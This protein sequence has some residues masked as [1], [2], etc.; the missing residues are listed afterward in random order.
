MCC[1]M[2]FSVLLFF[3][4]SPCLSP[5]VPSCCTE[6]K[7]QSPYRGLPDSIGPAFDT[8]SGHSSSPSPSLPTVFQHCADLSVLPHTHT[9]HTSNS[10][11]FTLFDLPGMLFLRFVCLFV[12][13]F[14]PLCRPLYKVDTPGKFPWP[15]YLKLNPPL[16]SSICCFSFIFI[17]LSHTWHYNKHLFSIWLLSF[18]PTGM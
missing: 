10:E 16:W 14:P 9:L 5:P 6:N 15:P 8:L 2:G 3:H 12:S 18:S 1:G 11:P 4:H 17:R 7:I 13:C